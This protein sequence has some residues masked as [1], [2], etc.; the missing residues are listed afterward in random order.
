MNGF[1]GFGIVALLI[2]LLFTQ[3]LKLILCFL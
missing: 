3:V 2:W 1:I